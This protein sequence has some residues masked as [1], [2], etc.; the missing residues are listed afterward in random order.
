MARQ[1]KQ[2]RLWKCTG[3]GKPWTEHLGVQGTCEQ[4]QRAKKALRAVVLW[5]SSGQSNMPLSV[6][7]QIAKAI[8]GE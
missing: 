3:C 6:A 5:V 7:K 1:T 8:K 2:Q 4:L